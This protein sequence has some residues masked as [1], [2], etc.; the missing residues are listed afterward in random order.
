[1]FFLGLIGA[2]VSV[3]AAASAGWWFGSREMRV[4]RRELYAPRAVPSEP[5]KSSIIAAVRD[6]PEPPDAQ[7][8]DQVVLE[9][10]LRM[11]ADQHG[12]DVASL[13]AVKEGEE[14]NPEA[15]AWSAGDAPPELSERAL[16]L[17]A[18]SGETDLI[19]I[20]RSEERPEAFIAVAPVREGGFRGALALSFTDAHG[21][22][23]S[24]PTLRAWLPR[25]ARR[26]GTLF[27][28]LRTR[29]EV[30]RVNYRL[31][32]S[33]RA[34]MALQGERDPLRLTAK[35]VEDTLNV[36]GCEWS[37]LVRWDADTLMGD[38]RAS[39]REFVGVDGQ[40]LVCTGAVGA[41]VPGPTV[42]AGTIVGDA[43]ADG[44]M[45]ACPD[46]RKY[47]KD[48]L[49]DGLRAPRAGSML[50]V[51]IKRGT[52]KGEPVVGALVCGHSWIGA[53]TDS[54]ARQVRELTVIAAGALASAWDFEAQRAAA[55]TDSLT[56]LPNRRLFDERFSEIVE[57]LDRQDDASMALVLADI[58]LFKAVNDTYGHEAGDEVLKA[59]ATALKSDRRGIDVVARLGGEE[60]AVLL[61]N[62]NATAAREIAERLRKRVGEMRVRVGAD[63]ITV[64]ASFG[65]AT[66]NAGAGDWKEVFDRADKAL[67]AAKRYG[68]DRVELA[69]EGRPAGAARIPH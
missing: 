19:S 59:L 49:I 47:D 60:F 30:A 12:A 69:P 26:L 41:E 57:W 33:M 36:A 34:A 35:L 31:R 3:T 66:Y 54:D 50:V 5:L 9:N 58:D 23:S 39:T 13:W 11:A 61:P 7:R 10:A 14:S 38:V 17:I 51:P 29:G 27:E 22:I 43:C 48:F 8:E 37:M 18:W 67:Y 1:M 65:V 28:V 46:V 68:R 64:T 2:L 15:I 4:R 45:I 32:H 42:G 21:T 20:D 40:V 53:L 56:G 16:G 24:R 6:V 62:A 44:G 25:H 52:D 63:T 55:R